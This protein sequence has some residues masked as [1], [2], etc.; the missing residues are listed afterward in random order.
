MYINS[1]HSLRTDEE[2]LANL[3]KVAFLL[4]VSNSRNAE[5]GNFNRIANS[6]LGISSLFGS[7]L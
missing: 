3:P 7:I 5:E 1:N 4:G 2:A 6:I